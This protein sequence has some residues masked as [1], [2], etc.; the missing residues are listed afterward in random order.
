[1]QTYFFLTSIFFLAASMLLLVESL[2]SPKVDYAILAQAL[3]NIWG[4]IEAF[5]LAH[6]L[7][8]HIDS[9]LWATFIVLLALDLAHA[10]RFFVISG[11]HPQGG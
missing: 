7:P 4:M 6:D 5:S 3:G 11:G 9:Q 2:G 8:L 1:M 10:A